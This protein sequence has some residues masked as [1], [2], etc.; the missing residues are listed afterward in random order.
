VR[1]WIVP[2]AGLGRSRVMSLVEAAANVL[3]ACSSRFQ[4]RL[5]CHRFSA[6]VVIVAVPM[7]ILV[8]PLR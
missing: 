1:D 3:T 7:L 2:F 4:P 6:L 8:R 5:S